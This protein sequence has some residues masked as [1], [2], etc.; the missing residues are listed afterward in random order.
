VSGPDSGGQLDVSE[1]VDSPGGTPPVFSHRA[2]IGVVVDQDRH[3]VAF[4]ELLETRVTAPGGKDHS[5]EALRSSG[6]HR[7]RNGHPDTKQTLPGSLL[8]LEASVAELNYQSTGTNGIRAHGMVPVVPGKNFSS[9]IG[10]AYGNMGGTHVHAQD[11]MGIILESQDDRTPTPT[12]RPVAHF[13]DQTGR[14]ELGDNLR[15]GGTG[16]TRSAGNFGPGN[17]TLAP[18][19]LQDRVGQRAATAILMGVSP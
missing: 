13:R 3:P 4:E 7:S 18:D 1:V 11:H 19:Q 17:V 10:K 15:N 5:S 14:E 2:E 6:I 16:Q 8:G 9:K 12:A